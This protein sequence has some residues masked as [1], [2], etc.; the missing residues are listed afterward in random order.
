MMG[1]REKTRTLR[2]TLEA[3]SRDTNS[4]EK[5]QKLIRKWSTTVLIWPED[6]DSGFLLKVENGKI[7]QIIESTTR[8]D[9]KVKVIGKSDVITNMFKGKENL[10]HLYMD[11][12]V[13][14][15]GSEKDQIVL[16]AV[17][18]LLWN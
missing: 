10:A 3:F 5:V 17:A 8:E 2:E 4:N 1:S 11:G 9:G 7:H 14:T 12:V 16:D 15:Y 18:R 13:Q 6:L